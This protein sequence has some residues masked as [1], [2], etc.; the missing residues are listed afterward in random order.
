MTPIVA[1]ASKTRRAFNFVLLFGV[2]SLCADVTYEGARSI[3]G[4]YLSMLGATATIVG[5]VAG[6]GSSE[7]H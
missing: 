4:P 2:V 6:G 1:E 5:V 3:T 7:V